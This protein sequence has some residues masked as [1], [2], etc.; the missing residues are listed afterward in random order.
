MWKAIYQHLS[1]VLNCY[2]LRSKNI[3]RNLFDRYCCFT[4][5]NIFAT[6]KECLLN[7]IMCQH[8]LSHTKW[9]SQIERHGLICCSNYSTWKFQGQNPS[10]GSV[11]SEHIFYCHTVLD[12]CNIVSNCKKIIIINKDHLLVIQKQCDTIIHVG[13]KETSNNLNVQ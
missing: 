11:I 13:K 4:S 9:V 6:K 1:R 2:A 7:A 8:A 12:P 5:T 10:P 3:F